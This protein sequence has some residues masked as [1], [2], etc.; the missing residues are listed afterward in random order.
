MEKSALTSGI[1][2]LEKGEM[3]D[4]GLSR[5]RSSKRFLTAVFHLRLIVSQD[6]DHLEVKFLLIEFSGEVEK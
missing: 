6:L 1:F 3:L 5:L 2:Q 4:V